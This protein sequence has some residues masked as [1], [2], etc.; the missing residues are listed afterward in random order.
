M[1]LPRQRVVIRGTRNDTCRSNASSSHVSTDR[2]IT[3]TS[4]PLCHVAAQMSRHKSPDLIHP[5]FFF[6]SFVVQYAF[7]C[8]TVVQGEF[9]DALP[10]HS[11]LIPCVV[12][13]A[14][15]S[16]SW[17]TIY[18]LLRYVRKWYVRV[19]MTGHMPCCCCRIGG[20]GLSKSRCTKRSHS[21]RGDMMHSLVRDVQLCTASAY[22]LPSSYRNGA[23]VPS[24]ST[25]IRC[26]FEHQHTVQM[27]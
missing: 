20:A 26:K 21:L 14:V 12:E 27:Y 9:D 5:D 1:V 13:P 25:N 16:S 17:T 3:A 8:F 19:D 15:V 23:G 22:G 4:T 2:S 11:W 24:Y 6:N 7:W 18:R 10:S